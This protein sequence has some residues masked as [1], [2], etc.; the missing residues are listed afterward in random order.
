MYA[1]MHIAIHDAL[2]AI[3]RRFQPCAFD[4]ILLLPE[5]VDDYVGPDNL[6]A[7][8]ML[9]VD[10]LDLAAAAFIRV[11]P[12]VTGLS[13]LCARRSAEALHLRLPEPSTVE[14]SAGG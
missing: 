5:A 6:C 1:M 12:K 4:K 2:N 11:E 14:P 13:G 10:G 3:D 9:F 8:L 7:S